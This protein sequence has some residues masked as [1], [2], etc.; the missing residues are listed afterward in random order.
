MKKTAIPTTSTDRGEWALE[1]MRNDD[2]MVIKKGPETESGRTEVQI[3]SASSGYKSFSLTIT[4]TS[5]PLFDRRH[6]AWVFVLMFNND[7]MAIE[8]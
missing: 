4:A 5:L 3:L 8:R 7:L 1:V 6:G 2:L